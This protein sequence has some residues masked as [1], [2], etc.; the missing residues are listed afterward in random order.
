MNTMETRPRK[1]KQHVLD[2]KVCGDILAS[3]LHLT[4]LQSLTQTQFLKTEQEAC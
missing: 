4:H 1:V 3:A 2:L